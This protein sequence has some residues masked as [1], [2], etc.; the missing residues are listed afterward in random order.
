[1]FERRS[2]PLL[3]LGLFVGRVT[4]SLVIAA[5]I[6]VVAL[7]IGAV[8]FTGLEGLSWADSFL[9]SALVLTGNGPIARMGTMGGKVFLLAYAL[10]GVVV[11]AAVISVVVAPLLHR[12]LHAFHIDVT[13]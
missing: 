7:V 4:W 11:F 6:D 13:D 9:N 8:G 2:E 12:V 3:P 10:A 5:V 1:M